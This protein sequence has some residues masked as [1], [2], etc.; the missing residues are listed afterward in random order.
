[1]APTDESQEKALEPQK[2]AI[3]K[4]FKIQGEKIDV[5]SSSSKQTRKENVIQ[6]SVSV[7]LP[8]GENHAAPDDVRAAGHMDEDAL[9]PNPREA[10]PA[11]H[12]GMGINGPP[13]NEKIHRSMLAFF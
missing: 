2:K 4:S 3:E 5:P 9:H 13:F 11:F 8:I 1:M 7:L 12:G 6:A 10:I